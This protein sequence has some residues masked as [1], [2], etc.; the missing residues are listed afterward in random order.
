M[1]TK[2]REEEGGGDAVGSHYQRINITVGTVYET[3]NPFR[4]IFLHRDEVRGRIQKLGTSHILTCGTGNVNTLIRHRQ[5]HAHEHAIGHNG[6]KQ[7][8]ACKCI[9]QK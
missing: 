5:Q 1:R 4:H 7:N 8:T 2:D 9:T 6:Q 3:C